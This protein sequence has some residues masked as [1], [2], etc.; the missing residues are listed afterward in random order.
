[1]NAAQ[2][3]GQ[4][5]ADRR[6][7]EIKNNAQAVAEWERYQS[8]WQKVIEHIAP[9]FAEGNREFR[10]TAERL[11]AETGF[12]PPNG[13]AVSR[14]CK[15]IGADPDTITNRFDLLTLMED[16]FALKV[17]EK[18]I[19]AKAEVKASSENVKPQAATVA[20][21]NTAQHTVLETLATAGAKRLKN[22]DIEAATRLA[23]Q[24]VTK[25]VASLIESGFA[26]RPDGQRGGVEIT[27]AGRE[28]LNGRK[29]SD[30]HP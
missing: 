18:R 17:M 15:L 1:M 24:T 12:D 20:T 21:L 2:R 19:D 14:I 6:E 28:A 4:L 27:A 30:N 5:F 25:A 16:Y 13:A 3:A 23:K 22:V 29:S 8:R 7:R 11:T 9:L 10:D 26:E